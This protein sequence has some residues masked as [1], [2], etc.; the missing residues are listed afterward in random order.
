MGPRAFRFAYRSSE[1]FGSLLAF[2]PDS[3]RPEEVEFSCT[4][5]VPP[6]YSFGRSR[7]DLI[8]LVFA[9]RDDR[10][11]ESVRCIF[12]VEGLEDRRVR[13]VRSKRS[14]PSFFSFGVN[15]EASRSVVCDRG[16]GV[17]VEVY[18]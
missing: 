9:G 5:I 4:I 16:C 13:D 8:E 11:V 3:G 18:E 6:Y 17:W 2:D 1:S 12:R 15:V 14:G 10:V 7:F